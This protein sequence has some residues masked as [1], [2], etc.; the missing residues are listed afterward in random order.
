LL[1]VVI[2]MAIGSALMMSA[3]TSSVQEGEMARLGTLRR[4]AL[5]SAESDLWMTLS[6]LHSSSLRLAP[7][8]SISRVSHS[9]GDLTLIVTVEKVDTANVWIVAIATIHRSGLVARHRLG[10]SAFIPRDT[11]DPVVHP[12]PERAWAELF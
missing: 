2:S 8:G 4:R 3:I 12:V 1:L 7:V 9:S 10:M 6:S 11:A 5:V